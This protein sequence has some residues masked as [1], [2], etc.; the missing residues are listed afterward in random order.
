MKNK[1]T[2][3]TTAQQRPNGMIRA[4][5]ITHIEQILITHMLTKYESENKKLH[6]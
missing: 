5:Y 4:I 2:E 6:K 3:V 1:S